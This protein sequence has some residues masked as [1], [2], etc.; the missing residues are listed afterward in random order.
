MLVGPR[1]GA[2]EWQSW[3]T[4]RARD[5]VAFGGGMLALACFEESGSWWFLAG[6]LMASTSGHLLV[7]GGNPLHGS[8]A[9]DSRMGDCLWEL[10][11]GQRTG[12]GEV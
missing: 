1:T 5:R 7:L 4:A 10:S 2:S 3:F 11:L 8:D 12:D 9:L 6:F